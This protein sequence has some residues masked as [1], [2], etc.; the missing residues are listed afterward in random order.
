MVYISLLVSMTVQVGIV[1][2]TPVLS[3]LV[4]LLVL[5]CCVVPLVNRLLGN[6]I[7]VQFLD[8][9]PLSHSELG[10]ISNPASQHCVRVFNCIFLY[11]LYFIFSCLCFTYTWHV[12]LLR[13]KC[14]SNLTYLL[15]MVIF[16]STV[17]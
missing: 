11:F 8:S 13:N 4:I 15:M 2:S 1:R 9:T 7:A 16:E 12:Y 6:L 17:T 5:S 14:L 3:V 10:L